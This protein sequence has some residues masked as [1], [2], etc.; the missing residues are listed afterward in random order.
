M[1]D[2]D[3]AKT[4]RE[5]LVDHIRELKSLLVAFS[6]GTDSTFLL[7]V[8]HEILGEKTLA[9]TASSVIHPNK[10]LKDARDFTRKRDIKHI[11]F[12]SNEMKLPVF[13]SN[14]AD[15]CYHCKHHLF[16]SVFAIAKE[17]GI[18]HV[19]H[20]A[21]LD[22]LNDYRPGLRAATESGVL[23]PLI[24]AGLNKEEIRFL[25][26]KMNLPAWN[27][28]AQP[29]L[30]T[31]IPYKSPITRKKLRMI[32]QA[33]TF[34]LEKGFQE[35][36]VRHYGNLAII[37]INDGRLKNILNKEKR[38]SVLEKLHEIGFEHIALDLEGYVSGK[39]NRTLKGEIE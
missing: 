30:A 9:V 18:V 20:G 22:D 31:R 7:A 4:K 15:R 14:N 25:S 35:I 29:C 11:V 8:A 27:R 12:P 21:N 16:E 33:E 19:A 1:I 28:P 38:K 3:I 39:M 34:L 5:T 13:V 24:D 17:K 26:H 10:E 32:E 2:K 36:R 23:A 37:E 6:G